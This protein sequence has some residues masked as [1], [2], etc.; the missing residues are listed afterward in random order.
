MVQASQQLQAV[1]SYESD[2]GKLRDWL[3]G[4]SAAT[5]GFVPPGVTVDTIKAQLTEVEVSYCFFY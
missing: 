1:L 4:Q 5:T 3:Q 2:C